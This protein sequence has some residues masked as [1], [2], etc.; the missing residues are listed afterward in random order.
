ML[1]SRV[2]LITII[3]GRLGIAFAGIVSVKVSTMLLSPEQLGSIS[4][5]NSMVNLF[6]LVLV[7]PVAHFITRGF[8]D[9][10]E[11]DHLADNSGKY[12]CYVAITALAATLIAG[13]LQW[14]CQLVSNFSIPAIL[15]L[16]GLNMV[17]M[18]LNSFGSTGFNLLGKRGVNVFFTNLVAWASLLFSIGLFYI[19]KTN[20]AWSLGQ[21]AGFIAGSF[22]V[23]ILWKRITGRRQTEALPIHEHAIVFSA[24][25][26]FA[27]SWPFIF[28]SGLWWVQ[29]QSYR[30]ILD[31][32]QGLAD[33]G[34]FSVA[35]A[36]AS[37]PI[38]LYESVIGQYL[39]PT[40]FGELKN[41]GKEGQVRAWNK[42]AALYLPGMA[43]TG[44]FIAASTPFLA[45]IF[46]GE[47]FRLIAVKV[48]VW[49]ALIET[50]RAAGAMVFQLGMAKV[51]NRM[52]ILPAVAGA[53][54]APVGVYYF[55]RI[56][57]LYGT[58]AGLFIAGLIVL[59][60]NV[61]VSYRVLPISWPV[62]R[63]LLGL[64]MAVPALAALQ[65]VSYFSPD[66]GYMLSFSA[67]ALSGLYIGGVLV[68]VLAGKGKQEPI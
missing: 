21:A 5:L 31:K 58:I 28:T 16:V 52:T 50:M 20:V 2:P 18:P 44:A 48:T 47:A 57:P 36:L 56:H 63:I 3:V 34:Y 19:Y 64:L 61:I 68:Y 22:S 42:L 45:K 11:T 13:V 33:V 6:N 39:E 51:D 15:F 26:I 12:F 17:F 7:I 30:F 60:I 8:L 49:A 4:Q 32:I 67:L 38:M 59:A 1:R 43:V 40:F 24:G 37:M 53:A 23:F 54:L 35:Y 66:P 27:F 14:Q 9:W 41:Q 29:T 65:L 25:K 55:G 46:L 10:Y 62:K